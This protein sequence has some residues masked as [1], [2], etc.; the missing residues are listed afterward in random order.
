MTIVY[1]TPYATAMLAE[2]RDALRQRFRVDAERLIGLNL[3][4]F[5]ADP[6]AVAETV[7]TSPALPHTAVF[8]LGGRQ[9]QLVATVLR[10]PDGEAIGYIA[11]L[12]DVS[13]RNAAS[14]ALTGTAS[15]LGAASGALSDATG[16][17]GTANEAV[18][19]DSD[20]LS[21]GMTE[22]LDLMNSVAD[23]A[24]MIR[25][26]TLAVV[27]SAH[28]AGGNVAE[29]TTASATISEFTAMISSIAEQTKLLALNA[30]IEATRAGSAGLGFAVVAQEVKDL[31]L[32]AAGAA[33]KISD[34]VESIQRSSEAA[35][36]ALETITDKVDVVGSQQLSVN[37]IVDNQVAKVEEI[38]G[39]TQDLAGAVGGLSA[40]VEATRDCAGSILDRAQ[41]LDGVVAAIG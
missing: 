19:G 18:A 6:A 22:L 14:T 40:A 15:E 3:R 39:I 5:H 36:R 25:E 33:G 9:I 29:L 1:A 37:V 10:R 21:T 32:R 27:D 24:A 11:T 35:G 20:A 38:V 23:G 12:E 41:H 28:A 16:T 34:I 30:T 17:L 26:S 8:D 31:A 4:A 2:L 7:R 13:A